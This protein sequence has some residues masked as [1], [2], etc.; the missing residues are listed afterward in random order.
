MLGFIPTSK[1]RR[2]DLFLKPFAQTMQADPKYSLP[3]IERRWLASLAE[4]GSLSSFPCREIIDLYIHGTRL[5]LRRID[6][7]NGT[8]QFKLRPH[9]YK[10]FRPP[11]QLR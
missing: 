10:L 11:T 8:V 9:K 2:I 7:P 1:L 4:V 3:E 6:D 5:R